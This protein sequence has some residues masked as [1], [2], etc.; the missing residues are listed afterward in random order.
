[1]G[2]RLKSTGYNFAPGWHRKGNRNAG[3]QGEVTDLTQ[4]INTDQ[5][6]PGVLYVDADNEVLLGVADTTGEIRALVVLGVGLICTL[7]DRAQP[8]YRCAAGETVQLA[9]DASG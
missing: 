1:M 5:I 7:E 8:I 4:L 6:E 2:W 3:A 9:Q